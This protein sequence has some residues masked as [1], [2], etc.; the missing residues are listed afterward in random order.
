MEDSNRKKLLQNYL[1]HVIHAGLPI[2]PYGEIAAH[3]HAQ[4]RSRLRKVGVQVPSSDAQIA[5]IAYTN[6]LILVTRNEKDFVHFRG[7]RIENW[8]TL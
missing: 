1:D 4:E 7:L 8:F 5:A 2:L 6:D 3:W